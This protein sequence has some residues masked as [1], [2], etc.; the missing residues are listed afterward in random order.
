MGGF[1]PDPALTYDRVLD[2]IAAA[3]FTGTELGD[4]GFMPDNPVKLQS[5]LVARGLEMIGAFTPV[6]LTDSDAHGESVAAA[7]RAARLLKASSETAARRSGPFVILA[8]AST[9]ERLAVAGRVGEEHGLTS[10]QW[11]ALAGGLSE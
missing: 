1:E 11:K 9:R 3:G 4:W 10:P 7:L 5:E 8:E 6:R 2:D